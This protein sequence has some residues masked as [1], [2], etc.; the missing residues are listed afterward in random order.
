LSKEMLKRLIVFCFERDRCFVFQTLAFLLQCPLLLIE[1]ESL[2]KQ[3][4]KELLSFQF[5][6]EKRL[7]RGLE[8]KHVENV[9]SVRPEHS[10]NSNQ[11]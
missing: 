7:Q 10:L 3:A 8:T 6:F 4:N 2:G 1:L 9:S 11:T 5:E